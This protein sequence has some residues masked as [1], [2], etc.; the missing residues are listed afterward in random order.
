MNVSG[1]DVLVS[2]K[3]GGQLKS[4]VKDAILFLKAN[5]AEL[6]RLRCFSGVE[7]VVLDFGVFGRDVP[8]E[9]NHFPSSLIQL[10][11]EIGLSLEL[12]IYTV[13]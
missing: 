4:Q 8:A 7:E 9:F 11:G 13:F 5:R 1:F 10:A 3:S 12:S 6:I 2:N